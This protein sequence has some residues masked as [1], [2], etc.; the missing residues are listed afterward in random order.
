LR[1]PLTARAIAAVA[2]ITAVAAIE[3]PAASSQG[4]PA[5]SLSIVT[6]PAELL[7][8]R[9]VTVR[10][11]LA[12]APGTTV[13][14]VIELQSAPF[15]YRRYSNL[16]HVFTAADG[17]F[18]FPRRKPDRNTRYRVLDVGSGITS[19]AATVYVDAPHQLKARSLGPG[20]VLLTIVTTHPS[21]LV[22]HGATV[23]WFLAPPGSRTWHLAATSITS[24]LRRGVT[25]GSVIVDPPAKRFYFIACLNPRDEGAMG[26]P[27]AHMPC[28]HHDFRVRPRAR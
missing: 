12:G 11:V 20:Q 19:P 1:R 7:L 21:S 6:A 9:S 13:G 3:A 4:V 10:G 15:P 17:S 23:Y 26:P 8:G 28:P 16:A 27:A 18:A 14:Q 25:L 5:S 22:W 2:T 24:D